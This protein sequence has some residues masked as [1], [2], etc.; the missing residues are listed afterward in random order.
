[1]NKTQLL[2]NINGLEK[3]YKKIIKLEQFKQFKKDLKIIDDFTTKITQENDTTT[4]TQKI[5]IN[6]N[7]LN[8]FKSLANEICNTE[9][10]TILQKA[11]N[12]QIKKALALAIFENTS[13]TLKMTI[14]TNTQKLYQYQDITKIFATFKTTIEN[15]KTNNKTLS[16]VVDINTNKIK[17]VDAEKIYNEMMAQKQQ[18]KE[19]AK[20]ERKNNKA[21]QN[22]NKPKI[23][24]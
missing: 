21:K 23:K 14:K 4:K 13:N 22:E 7:M 5:V 3:E 24:K 12:N 8:N 20:Q 9:T 19:N 6:A 17:F 2:K 18:E 11:T 10:L 1:M 16:I 15:L